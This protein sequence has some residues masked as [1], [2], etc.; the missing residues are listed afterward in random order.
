MTNNLTPVQ[1][2]VRLVIYFSVLIMAMVLLVSS[3]SPALRY[4]PI[5]SADIL[6]LPGVTLS[7]NPGAT[8]TGQDESDQS[9]A[10][11][12][13]LSGQSISHF[14]LF[15]TAHLAATI[16]V[17]LP[18]TW[19]YSATRFEAGPSSSFVQ[20]LLLMPL[21]ATTVVLLV[22]DSLALAFGL[23]ALVAAVRFRIDL[24][25][26][27]DGIY[28]FAA[29]CVGLAA[30]IGYIGAAMILAVF[31]CLTNAILWATGYGRNPVDDARREARVAK[32]VAKAA[33][34]NA[35]HGT[36]MR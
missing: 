29:I 26:T 4:L 10:P 32:L 15:L 27:I 2:I 21:C 17:M 20:T 36:D 5:G 19:T 16:V 34:D 11:K 13:L 23:A 24:P 7:E 9:R 30:G 12:V 35:V 25:E 33:K 8:A 18:I 3:D 1:L 31:F 6:D 28:I 14:V 22:Q